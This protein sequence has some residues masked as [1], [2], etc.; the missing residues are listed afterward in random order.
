MKTLLDNYKKFQQQKQKQSLLNK[1]FNSFLPEAV[2]R[3][4]K[5]ENDDITRKQVNTYL[6]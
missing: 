1:F 5:I 2:Y 4:T 3:T 6:S